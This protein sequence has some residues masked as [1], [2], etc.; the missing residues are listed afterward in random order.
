MKHSSILLPIVGAT[1]LGFS[2]AA[3][4]QAV[5]HETKPAKESTQSTAMHTK[6]V[7][8]M[9]TTKTAGKSVMMKNHGA[10]QMATKAVLKTKT[11]APT[12]KITTLTKG[13]RQT[14]K[15]TSAHTSQTKASKTSSGSAHHVKHS[16][17]KDQS[18]AQKKSKS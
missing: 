15:K 17:K 6:R 9:A 2:V 4:Q 1:L 8:H 7:K 13:A 11:P 3:A 18:Q 12:K 5:T 10:S 16:M 14:E